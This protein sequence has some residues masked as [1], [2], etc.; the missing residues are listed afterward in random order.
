M[1]DNHEEEHAS[2]NANN[3]DNN[4]NDHATPSDEAQP[5]PYIPTPP[6]ILAQAVPLALAAL[7]DLVRDTELAPRDR[8]LAA[9]VVLRYAA[10]V[11]PTPKP[12]SPDDDDDTDDEDEDD[13]DPTPPR[14]PLAD[15]YWDGYWDRDKD[16]RDGYAH[17]AHRPDPRDAPT[18]PPTPST[19]RASVTQR[20]TRPHTGRAKETGALSGGCGGQSP[21]HLHPTPS[22][23]PGRARRARTISRRSDT[24]GGAGA[25]KDT[26]SWLSRIDRRDR[27]VAARPDHAAPHPRPHREGPRDEASPISSAHSAATSPAPAGRNSAPRQAAH[28]PAAASTPRTP[29]TRREPHG[30]PSS[31]R[32]RARP[33]RERA[34]PPAANR[35]LRP[36]TLPFPRPARGGRGAGAG[37]RGSGGRS[38]RGCLSPRR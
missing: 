35:E 23:P 15:R 21:L 4:T 22:T 20:I 32:R 25:P 16:L 13:T 2:A 11:T 33:A 38:A 12:P 7:A 1:H 36:T 19:P 27:R 31:R 34:D 18:P 24:R 37:A 5:A 28:P 26:S 14:S 30:P 8:R 10:S 3:T 9:A 17:P 6:A 29:W